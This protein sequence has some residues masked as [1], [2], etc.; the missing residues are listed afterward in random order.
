MGVITDSREGLAL[1]TNLRWLLSSSRP[2]AV[3]FYTTKPMD[4]G[5]NAQVWKFGYGSNMSLEF[6]RN[7]KGLNPLDSRRTV[8]RGFSLSFPEG[9]GIDFVEPSFATMKRDPNGT[10]HGVSILFAA[11]DKE[12]LD[13][14]EGAPPYGTNYFIEVCPLEVYGGESLDAE[15]YVSSKPLPLDLPEGCCSERYRDI[16][17]KGAME[18]DLD[19]DWISKLRAL[20]VEVL[21]RRAALPSPSEL[22]AM[23]IEELKQHNGEHEGTP[24]Y[25]SC[26]GYI[27]DLTPPFKSHYGRDITQRNAL[28]AR[29][30]SLDQNDDG[31]KSPFP[32]LSQMAPEELEYALRYRD[33]CIHHTS[34]PIAVLLE[35]WQ[36][37]D[38]EFKPVYSQNTL[39]RL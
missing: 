15:V 5:N 24:V 4:G 11:S 21:A 2:R 32:R 37:Q 38:V 19:A 22:P 35:F 30:V 12:N 6:V 17:V 3:R 9:H 36:E 20:P 16:L 28:Q 14:Q 26:C 18:A 8:L 10:V 39:S 1:S 31:G 34:G 33:R 13:K 25:A 29:G 27:F 7:K 23:T